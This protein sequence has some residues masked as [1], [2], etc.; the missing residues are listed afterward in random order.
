MTGCYS[1]DIKVHD[2]LALGR[3]F[4]QRFRVLHFVWFL[5]LNTI[6]GDVQ[7]NIYYS[8]NTSVRQP[9]ITKP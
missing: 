3:V 7:V 6:V 8:H 1:A 4:K 5:C 9:I 2:S